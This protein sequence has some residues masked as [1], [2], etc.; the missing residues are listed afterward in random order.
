MSEKSFKPGVNEKGGE[1][2]IDAALDELARIGSH[3]D[4]DFLSGV[5]AELDRVQAKSVPGTVKECTG[6]T[7]SKKKTESR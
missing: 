7:P 2:L 4:E 5:E 6:Y 3:P 1:H